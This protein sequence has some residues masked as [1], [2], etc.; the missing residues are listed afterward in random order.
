MLLFVVQILEKSER[1]RREAAAEF[2]TNT[3]EVEYLSSSGILAERLS[4]SVSALGPHRY[5]VLA[6]FGLIAVR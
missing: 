1:A 2:K 6:D 5:A 3:A 4:D